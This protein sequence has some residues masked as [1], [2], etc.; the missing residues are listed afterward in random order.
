MVASDERTPALRQAAVSWS[1]GLRTLPM[2][3]AG[4]P[5]RRATYSAGIGSPTAARSTGAAIRD[6]LTTMTLFKTSCLAG[7]RRSAVFPALGLAAALLAARSQPTAQ[8]PVSD[9]ARYVD[10][11]IGTAAGGNV[12]PGAV[13]PFGMVQWSPETTRG[14][15]TRV[16]APGGYAYDVPRVRGF[17]LTHLSGTGCR[18]ASGDIPFFPYTGRLRSSPAADSTDRFYAARFAHANETA[19]PGYYQVRL[20]S[21]VNVELTATARTGTGRFT[22]PAGDTATLLIR[23]SDSEVGSGDAGVRVDAAAHTVSG[24]VKSGNFCGYID[25]VSRHDYYTLYF[26]AE[27]DRAFDGVGV[28]ERDSLMPGNTAAAGGTTYGAGGYPVVGQGS[29]AYV[30]FTPG[31]SPTV[32]V[33]VGI[34]YVSLANAAANL[35]AEHPPGTTFDDVRAQARAAW[36]GVLERVRIA[37]G[38]EPQRRVFYTALYHSLLHPNLLSD[39]NGQYAGFDG[40]V[41]TVAGPQRAQ[42]ANFSGWDVYRSQLQLVALLDPAVASDRAQSLLNQATQNGGVWDRWT[43]NTGATHVMAGDPS[44]PAVAGIVA[45]GGT[46]FDVAGAYA[47]LARAATVPTKLDL[48]D[49]GCRVMCV[50]QRPSLD[51]WLAIHYIAASSNAWGGAGETLEDVTADFALAELA[52]HAGDTAGEARFRERSGYWRNLFNPTA[53]PD[54][55]YIQDRNADGSWTRFDP[56]STRGFAEGS[57]AQ[58]TWMIPFDPAGLFAAMGGDSA[59]LRRLDAFFHNE[60]GSWALTGLG[61][62]KAEMDNEPSIGAPWLYLFA[63]RPDRA[64]ALIHE[65]RDRLWSDRPDG[66]P[67]NDD[68]G[69]M[70]SWFVWAALGL[71]PHYPGRAELL[72]TSPLFPEAVIRRANGVTITVRA[73]GA[74]ASAPYVRALRVGGRPSTRAWLPASFVARGGDLTFSLGDA[75]DPRWGTAPGDAPPSF[76]P[77]GR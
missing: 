65:V 59:A 72:L 61:G 17:S 68:L 11:L 26:L 10:P 48:S 42:Y 38:T 43:H 57:S 21:G 13:V 18:G 75:P 28:W 62:R 45:F 50:G 55:G 40:A 9:P 31:G 15:H 67:G 20:Q 74:G 44:A 4:P 6:I 53:T 69:A 54:G 35:R 36:N 71:Y 27:F 23:V 46:G 19:E 56:A 34:S 76:P 39:A 1:I 49:E 14:D 24:W 63:G 73:A 41:H 77:A 33:R 29:G 32:S 51:Q 66:I 60:D 58:Y 64:Q 3:S 7:H 16:A 25:P 70:S 22:F 5:A 8:D 52:R 2:R 47:S 12:F 30:R 37:G